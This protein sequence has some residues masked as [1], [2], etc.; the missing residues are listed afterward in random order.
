MSIHKTD[1]ARA[2]D[3]L[4]VSQTEF[5]VYLRI[6]D[7][8]MR[9]RVSGEVAP[10]ADWP[11]QLLRMLIERHEKGGFGRGSLADGS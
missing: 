4:G 1:I 10:H 8:T 7:R 6:T 2:L 5:A 3:A 11:I 9:R